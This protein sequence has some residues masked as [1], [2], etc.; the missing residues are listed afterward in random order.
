MTIKFQERQYYPALR[1]RPSEIE[2][3]SELKQSTKD[4]LIP[5]FT[6]GAWPKMDGLSESI[7]KLKSA[8][9]ERPCIVDLTRENAYQNDELTKLLNPSGNFNAWCDFIQSQNNFIPTIQMVQEAKQSQIIRQTRFLE[10]IGLNRVAFR[11]TDYVNDTSKVINAI[12]AMDSPENAL[13]IIDAGYIRE[14]MAASIAACVSAINDIREEIPEAIISIISTS[15]PSTVTQFLEVNSDRKSGVINILERELLQAIGVDAAIYGD[16]GSIHSKV[17]LAKGGKYTPQIE[18]PLYDAWAIERRPGLDGDGY[19]ETAKALVE[20]YPEILDE[21][22]WGSKK[23]I[24]VSQGNNNGMKVRSKWIATRVNIHIEKQLELS[25]T[26]T[27]DD[28]F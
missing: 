25:L 10:G 12:S 26:D 9:D 3:Y 20:R 8:V 19:I 21:D 5:I 1:T 2:G 14:T 7:S 4:S 28:E 18:Y 27:L 17:Y 24:E 16:H 22:Y 6:I 23:I 13:V 15:Y 11:I